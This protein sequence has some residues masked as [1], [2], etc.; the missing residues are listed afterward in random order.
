MKTLR[1]YLALDWHQV[2]EAVNEE[3]GK[4]YRLTIPLLPDFAVYGSLQEIGERFPEAL[5]SHIAGYLAVGK[6]IPEPLT[7]GPA[8]QEKSEDT[9]SAGGKTNVGESDLVA[10]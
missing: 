4:S 6:V 3:D 7:L 8:V 9:G 10:A 1:E 2:I 5:E